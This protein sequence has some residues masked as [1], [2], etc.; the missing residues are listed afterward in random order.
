VE[1]AAVS[2]SLAG[3]THHRDIDMD[4]D[5]GQPQLIHKIDPWKRDSEASA[6]LS[7]AV[8]FGNVAHGDDAAI[9]LEPIKSRVTKRKTED[10]TVRS[11]LVGVTHHRDI[12]MDF[13]Y[14]QPQLTHKIDPWKRDS[15]GVTI[16]DDP[17]GSQGRTSGTGRD[18]YGGLQGI[19]RN[20]MPKQLDGDEDVT[21]TDD[22]VGLQRA[23]GAFP[24]SETSSG[25]T[26]RIWSSRSASQAEDASIPNNPSG[27]P[28]RF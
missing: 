5:N 3:V 23:S 8:G 17:L 13:D 12:D 11:S 20:Q 4:F 24:S 19:M 26:K 7:S 28:E 9:H 18:Y 22:P 6:T 10:A 21:I 1:D 2:G 14:G 16:T 25:H 15:Q 27:G